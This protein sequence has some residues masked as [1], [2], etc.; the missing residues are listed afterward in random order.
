MRNV[1][2]ILFTIMSFGFSYIKGSVIYTEKYFTS[3]FYVSAMQAESKSV[4]VCSYFYAS[5]IHNANDN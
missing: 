3:C 1:F 2:I 4:R 5:K